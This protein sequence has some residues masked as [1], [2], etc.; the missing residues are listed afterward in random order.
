MIDICKIDGNHEFTIAD[1]SGRIVV[2]GSVPPFMIDDQPIPDQGDIVSGIGDPNTQYV[3][4]G[5]LAARPANTARLKGMTIR[6]VPNPSTVSVDGGETHLCTDGTV[7]LH[8]TQPGT[9]QVVVSS[10]PLL[11]AIFSVTQP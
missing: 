4:G 9:Y 2:S 7:E 6:D 1:K 3:R 11:D 8:F 5:A 10:W